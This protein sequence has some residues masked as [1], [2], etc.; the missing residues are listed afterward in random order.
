MR[1]RTHSDSKLRPRKKRKQILPEATREMIAQEAIEQEQRQLGLVE[2]VLNKNTAL[3]NT[4]VEEEGIT[5]RTKFC[6][7]STLN[8]L[9]DKA[10][11]KKVNMRELKEYIEAIPALRFDLHRYAESAARSGDCLLYTS[12]SPR[13]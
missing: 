10:S 2:A 6:G 3:I 1:K 8:I 5:L 11:E 13:D 7:V 9:L 12:P 4:I